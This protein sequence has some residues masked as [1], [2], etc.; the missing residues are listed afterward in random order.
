M[1]EKRSNSDWVKSLQSHT[2]SN[3]KILTQSNSRDY[4]WVFGGA[5][6]GAFTIFSAAYYFIPPNSKTPPDTSLV[7]PQTSNNINTSLFSIIPTP[8][9][10]SIPTPV[11]VSIPTPVPVSI[12]TPAP[13]ASSN[14]GQ[15]S[16][17]PKTEM[18][19]DSTGN[20]YEETYEYELLGE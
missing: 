1:E 9:P 14:M 2:N 13:V 10:V 4:Y 11:P 15:L 12:S 19:T 16:P 5:F 3:G 18:I 17:L 20:V 8:V 7:P 6:L